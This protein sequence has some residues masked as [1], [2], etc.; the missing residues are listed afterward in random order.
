MWLLSQWTVILMLL[1]TTQKHRRILSFFHI[2]VTDHE[3]M[4]ST[5]IVICLTNGC[6]ISRRSKEAQN[7]APYM[8][9]RDHLEH[10]KV[11]HLEHRIT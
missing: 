5:S 3:A 8:G 4:S 2:S 6:S 11:D 10:R 7:H 1:T 9:L